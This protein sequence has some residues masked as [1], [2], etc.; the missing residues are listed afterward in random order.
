MKQKSPPAGRRQQPAKVP[1]PESL[2]APAGVSFPIV[3]IG[4]SAGGLEALE[5]FLRHVPKG[6]GM[7]VVIIQHLDPG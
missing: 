2:A 3:G 7:A 4:A 1:R 5:Q 6:S